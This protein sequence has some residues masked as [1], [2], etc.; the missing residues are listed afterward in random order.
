M[1]SQVSPFACLLS[2]L[3]AFGRLN[4]DNEII[5]MRASGLS[6]LQISKT[7]MLMGLLVSLLVFWINDK[8]IPQALSYN[9]KIKTQMETGRKKEQKQ[10]VI[11]N[12]S[13]YGI[14]N[15]LYFINRFNPE[16][17][18]IENII[19]LEH[20]EKQNITRKIVAKKGEF[21]DGL[22]RFYHCITYD[23]DLHGQILGEPQ[24][25]EEEI[26]SIPEKPADFLKQRQRTEFM[27]IAQ[28][29]DYLWRLSK[30][31]AGSVIRGLKVD[32]YQRYAS[33]FTSMIIIFLGIPFALM[34]RRRS[35]G[36][37]SIGISLMVGFLYYIAD[38]VSIALGKGGV[39]PP[40]L[41][42]SLSHIVALASSFYLIQ[43][44]P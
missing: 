39:L 30:S 38:A 27:T 17:N 25:Y 40:F 23:F 37:S 22:W 10:G 33:P 41:A 44:M 2:T 8:V 24:Y 11:N 9:Q 26:M 31:G 28:I 15:R 32:L 34:M 3:Y 43:T 16:N 19:I 5:A 20:D 7:V 36:I 6:V 18:T 42:A 13:M 29:E 35:T 4:H 12:L 1:F 21:I 14:K